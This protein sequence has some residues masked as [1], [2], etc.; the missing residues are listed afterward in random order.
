MGTTRS[1]AAKK[2]I[3]EIKKLNL[4]SEKLLTKIEELAK[5][6]ELDL[7]SEE[8]IGA[9]EDVSQDDLSLSYLVAVIKKERSDRKNR[10]NKDRGKNNEK[11]CYQK[12][13]DKILQKL[14]LKEAAA[15][16]KELK[17]NRSTWDRWK[18]GSSLPTSKT[19]E[20][21]E[22]LPE[23]LA[24]D[25]TKGFTE[26]ELIKGDPC[27]FSRIRLLFGLRPWK[28]AIFYFKEA[29]NDKD[30]C[31]DVAILALKG[32]DIVY[33][34]DNDENFDKWNKKFVENL[35]NELGA[36][37]TAPVLSQICVIKLDEELDY[38]RNGFGVLN[39][40]PDSKKHIGYNWQNEYG[41]QYSTFDGHSDSLFMK[42]I[43]SHLRKI[44]DA[45]KEIEKRKTEKRKP[46][47]ESE[48]IFVEM[49]IL[50]KDKESKTEKYYVYE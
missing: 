16:Q 31:I 29:F 21:L 19:L 36:E 28:R 45:F 33:I 17:I 11:E 12:L 47:I 34:F 43:N 49:C 44:G 7:T 22:N 5:I 50:E 24:G 39:Y 42:A 46:N 14:G 15:L 18:T 8:L 32:C 35:N 48:R 10:K 30:R 3:A 20:T 26:M 13:F 41:G 6:E 25:P 23:K 27:S 1:S 4:P 2:Q 40:F 38:S 9:I 37:L